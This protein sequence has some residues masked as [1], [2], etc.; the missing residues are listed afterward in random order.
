M[1]DWSRQSSQWVG[2][3]FAGLSDLNN[4]QSDDSQ[5]WGGVLSD[6][7]KNG[8]GNT[9]H[10]VRDMAVEAGRPAYMDPAEWQSK[11]N[12]A[13]GLEK[14]LGMNQSFGKT[15]A[16]W[17]R[18]LE[19]DNAH[20]YSPGTAKRYASSMVA[21]L[22]SMAALAVGAA[23]VAR[24]GNVQ[25]IGQTVENG[26]Y[27]GS[28]LL[29][30]ALS[31]APRIAGT[32]GKV[33]NKV[34]PALG[35]TIIPGLAGGVVSAIPEAAME[36]QNAVDDYVAE[37][38]QNNTY[39][40]GQTEREA[41]G[42]GDKVFNMNMGLLS[43]TNSAETMATFTKGSSVFP[44]NKATNI[45]SR[46]IATMASEGL[47]EGSQQI[48][49]KHAADKPWSVTDDD[50]KESAL[51]GAMMGGIMHGGGRT[52]TWLLDKKSK[53][54]S[55]QEQPETETPA[56]QE[57]SQIPQE[58]IS[59][60]NNAI[61]IPTQK[62]YNVT[63][64][65]SNTGLT[66]LTETKLN[67][68]AR[69]YYNQF[70]KQL[71]ITSMK[72][73]GDGSSWHDS[74][75]AVDIVN[76]T[77]EN[78][79]EARSW[80]VAQGQ[81]YGLAALDEYSNPSANATGGHIHF[82]DHGEALAG[83]N[84]TQAESPR[85]SYPK[86]TDEQ[87]VQRNQELQDALS[88]NDITPE[89]SAMIMKMADD[90][91][92][93]PT[94][95]DSKED[96]GFS[97][98]LSKASDTHDLGSIAQLLPEETASILFPDKYG[99]VVNKN[100]SANMP[101]H[102][103]AGSRNTAIANIA[104]K[105]YIDLPK[106]KVSD[107]QKDPISKGFSAEP[108]ADGVVRMRAPSYFLNEPAVRSLIHSGGSSDGSIQNNQSIQ[109]LSPNQQE[110][111]NGLEKKDLLSN[112]SN[113]LKNTPNQNELS[114]QAATPPEVNNQ[115]HT[116]AGDIA[117]QPLSQNS[118]NLAH[119]MV[120]QNNPLAKTDTKTLGETLLSAAK[121]NGIRV[122]NDLKAGLKQNRP[123]AIDTMKNRLEE[124]GV[125]PA[126]L[127]TKQSQDET[128][129]E[130]QS[131][132]IDKQPDVQPTQPEA[133]AIKD[134]S[135]HSE[136]FGS[137]DDALNDMLSAFGLEKP[138]SEKG[139]T[140][141]VIDDSE[142]AL[143][144]ALKEFSAEMK[145]L[146]ANA[147]FNPKLMTAAFKVGMIHLQRGLNN[148]ADWSNAMTA[149]SDQTKPFLQSTWDAI[150]AYPKDLKFNENQMSAVMRYVGTQY[151]KGITDKAELKKQL[152]K[153]IGSEYAN[154][155]D[156]AYAGVIKYPTK[157]E[158]E[159]VN[160]NS[161]DKMASRN[162]EGQHKNAVGKTVPGRKSDGSGRQ[163]VQST[164]QTGVQ[165]RSSM[166]LH[167]NSTTSSGTAGD[168]RI[169][170][171]E[172]SDSKRSTGSTELSRSVRDSYEG[173]PV[174]DGRRTGKGTTSSKN[175]P[176]HETIKHASIK[177][178]NKNF[179]AGDTKNIRDTLPLLLPEQQDD[180]VFAEK[181]LLNNEKT[182]VLFTNGTG[183]GKTFTGLGIIKRFAM[184]GK[185]N[186]L[187]LSPNDKIN[188]E[189]QKAAKKYFSLKV[190]KLKDT[191]DQGNGII[192]TTYA[193][194]GD[195]NQLVNRDWDLIVADES[196]S[197]MS[198]EK[199]TTTHALDNLRAITYHDRGLS[200]RFKRL[201]EK[202]YA[203]V[204][205]IDQDIKDIGEASKNSSNKT[206]VESKLS[207][208][209]KK[210]KSLWD[211]LHKKQDK[212]M[213]DWVNIPADKKPKVTFLSATP[214][215]Y[216][217]NIDYAEGYLFD[218]GK[219]ESSRYNDPDGRE[220]FMM[221]NFG[222]RMR[223][224][225]LTRPEGNVDSSVMESQFHE[226]LRQSGALS[227]RMLTVDKDYDRG[228][229]LVDGGIGNKVDEGFEWLGDSKNGDYR[230]LYDYMQNSFKHHQRMYLLEAIKAR[231]AIDLIKKYK[232]TGKKVVV[233]HD[234]KK[235]G[236]IHPF[237]RNNVPLDLQA[238]YSEFA[239]KRPDLIHMNLSGLKS[240]IVTLQEAFGDDVLLFNGDVSK[241]DREK[242]VQ[243]F[244][245][246]TSGKDI[247][248]VQSDAGQAGISLHDTTGK[249]QRV[250][251]NLGM[252][253]KPVAAIQI[254]GRIYRVGQKSNAIFR[255][256]N[257]GTN[258]ERMA[259]ASKIAERAST[260]ENLALGNEARNLKDSFVNAFEDTLG[261]DEWKKNL[262]GS[263]GE[264][265]GGK[266][267]DKVR[268][269]DLSEFDRSKTFYYGCG[270]KN[271]KT[272]SSEGSDYFATPEPLG[273]KMVEWAN[274][275]PGEKVLEP[276]A[277]H[278][279]IS[280]WFPT[281]T[282][283]TMIEPSKELAASAQMSGSGKVLS[284]S[285]E[286]YYVGNKFDAI[287]M[288]PPFGSGGKTAIEHLA[289]A[290]KQLRDGGRV[291][292]IIPDGP[293]CNKHFEKWFYGDENAKDKEGQ[294]GAKDASLIKEI[295]LPN[296]VFE[297]AGTNVGTKILV[298]DKIENE[299][300]RKNVS[301]SVVDISNAKNIE[302]FFN[303]IKDMSIQ[304]RAK[305]AKPVTRFSSD[306][307]IPDSDIIEAIQGRSGDTIQFLPTE[308]LTDKENRISSLGKTLNCQVR[309]FQGSPELRGF[310]ASGTTYLNRNGNLS[311][312][313]TFWHETFHWMTR[314]NNP[315]FTDLKEAIQKYSILDKKQI[316]YYRREIA[317]G[318]MIDEQGKYIMSDDD[319]IEEMMADKM[320]DVAG[321]L[322]LSKVLSKNDPSLYERFVQFINNVLQKFKR[323]YLEPIGLNK[324]QG[325]LMEEKFYQMAADM[326]DAEGNRIFR[327]KRGELE[328]ISTGQP[329][330]EQTGF[331]T[332]N[333]AIAYSSKKNNIANQADQENEHSEKDAFSMSKDSTS[334]KNLAARAAKKLAES[335]GLKVKTASNVRVDIQSKGEKLSLFDKTWRSPSEIAKA[336]R[337]FSIFFRLADKAVALQEK[338][339]NSFAKD[340]KKVQF[341][342]K[343]EQDLEQCTAA[344][345][346]GD[347]EQKEYS[348][349][350]LKEMGLSDNAVHAYKIV[351]SKLK[352]A[353]NLINDARQQVKTRNKVMSETD[354]ETLRK[355]SFVEILKTIK[356]EDG[357]YLVSY[358]A[359]KTWSKQGEIVDQE[360][361]DRFKHDEN[362]QVT[363]AIL[364]KNGLYK[365]D[366]FEKIS[367]M[368]NRTGY[369]SHFFHEYMVMEKSKDTTTQSRYSYKVVGSG[370]KLSEA[371]RK[372]ND[373]A[374]IP[375]NKDKEYVIRSKQFNFDGQK[376]IAAVLGD[377]EFSQMTKQVADNTDMTLKE[378]REFLHE[379]GA[380]LKARHRFFGNMLHRKGSAGFE[381]DLFWV[382]NH[383][384]N[385]SSRYVAM[386]EFK[387]NAISQFERFF[388]RFDDDYSNNQTANYV[389]NYIN[390][391][392]GNPTSIEN[393]LNDALKGN[394]FFQSVLG[395]QFGDR[396][397][398]E[399][400]A[401]MSGLMAKAKL[402]FF[403]TSSALMNFMQFV[404]IASKV[405]SYE[406]AMKGLKKAL[407][408]NSL[409]QFI[410]DESGALNDI[411][412][413]ADAGG[414]SQRRSYA[415]SSGRLKGIK[416]A[417]RFTTDRVNWLMDKG[418]FLFSKADAMMRKTAV[419]A[420]YY[421][422]IETKGF[423]ITPGDKVSYKALEY[424][425]EV[426]R[427]AN[428]DYGAH[429]T[430]NMI[431]R[432]SVLTQ[433]MFQ[434]Q[435]YPIK[436]LEFMI[437]LAK[438]GDL[439]QNARFWLPF[440][441]IAGL[442]QFPFLDL[443]GDLIS[444]FTGMK[445]KEAAKKMLMDFGAKGPV[446]K[447]LA[448]TAMYGI[449]SNA[450]I[451]ISN[452]VGMA[453]FFAD[454]KFGGPF[455][456]TIGGMAKQ[457]G[458]G[459]P[460]ETIKAFSPA[461][462][463]MLQ[464][465]VGETR[466]TRNRVG[467]TYDSNYEKL[468]HALGFRTIDEAITNDLKDAMYNQRNEAK[469][470]EQGAIDAFIKN[471]TTENR[472]RLI[473]LKITPK[474]IENERR[475]KSLDNRERATDSMTKKQKEAMKDTLEF[476]E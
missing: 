52:A 160:S 271:S 275:K 405:N 354:L 303:R 209:K 201:N 179:K 214:F 149:S 422:G 155:V 418:M 280:R 41:V 24:S 94:G 301:S 216:V 130:S 140:F 73:D 17:G 374:N 385:S 62:F 269:E 170:T 434:F 460:I 70:G 192:V 181:R 122:N 386:E 103:V 261:T 444:T 365:V 162:G 146:S 138:V 171:E 144:A 243:L 97:E 90:I 16:D 43:G 402:G 379:S 20:S 420:A 37:A 267:K 18:N 206:A 306:I 332:G 425:K 268:R 233:F 428:F 208:L 469:E 80:L 107:F 257:T 242:N 417:A 295:K 358:K 450:G 373:I 300:L 25:S 100:D 191:K 87:I 299:A 156:S 348:V 195:N 340:M 151:D 1:S 91:A 370:K 101:K 259:F 19:E 380:G 36:K 176:D 53:P 304:D 251:M 401:G 427:A 158:I 21:S 99:A 324:A 274:I 368:V 39:V 186:I 392:N 114:N 347:A 375:E 205:K 152:E 157:E 312:Q 476:A 174:S 283:N 423:K 396:P 178:N 406:Y 23:G 344:L 323:L 247:I 131:I 82:S 76:D 194:M 165:S 429:D 32:I 95:L 190:S 123:I 263:E 436:Q 84:S 441:L 310:H 399:I 154:L 297:R 333:A 250:L 409:D 276:S 202:A 159:N 72:R 175:R 398:L 102:N 104:A 148:F 445:P 124:A 11:A 68:L 212:I 129:K 238:K 424:A 462:G 45:L 58:N 355:N 395:D 137:E 166:H 227:G 54:S 440:L 451:D 110:N 249:H 356:Q 65:V 302:E 349:K 335:T 305:N 454:V 48:I 394:P 278:G 74:G 67:L 116:T 272:K 134:T 345:W 222:Y 118:T 71:D 315:L 459:N 325:K 309:F 443:F 378:A 255:Y 461:L 433:N 410:I 387:P 40:P 219:K 105:G 215:A 78:D 244:N 431:R 314:N 12:S 252:P 414:Y 475:K 88:T 5:G 42:V 468:L 226:K 437:D 218:Y 207:L 415:K 231:G 224:N 448:D 320:T 245:D 262:P 31:N 141:N 455:V 359:P 133:P 136:R 337:T 125:D 200:N 311:P 135:S 447:T 13:E 89:H 435:K 119:N 145:N 223:Y 384:F 463:N 92:T 26:L 128:P 265:I 168:S 470:D 421:Q 232:D 10:T 426:D 339:R 2:N 446:E 182:G 63:G 334:V 46:M 113:I 127:Q 147:M 298:I 236:A 240:P 77:L 35:E 389:K 93:M 308:K 367:P 81:K 453:N 331:D 360:T 351:R 260:A 50:V 284:N 307:S 15:V 234:F 282:E 456:S 112:G 38:K 430:P 237:Q 296:V 164:N 413:S 180:V 111:A 364:Q 9:I 14:Y 393:A 281:D 139:K 457:V 86:L 286:D 8:I 229:I 57:Q 34:A 289:K 316:D 59:S 189:W 28:G 346:Q 328:A 290:Y 342:L 203:A 366:Y 258:T 169:R 115:E 317:M 442:G 466:T 361:L 285:F 106:N 403:N 388:G 329:L 412:I 161:A 322:G 69:D 381:K 225:K 241:K 362:M 49:Q 327:Q 79:P 376:E 120:M 47:E 438:K 343:K 390:D 143:N 471:P 56:A 372:A 121:Q 4:Q 30:D 279:A 51:V 400:S 473:E 321:R 350:D 96:I 458:N 60:G 239:S 371:I 83:E 318:E 253:V 474:R 196:Q 22:P 407:H 270:K 6:A 404:N 7:L 44:K 184:Q 3:D 221:E 85:V 326:R 341:Y 288:N 439:K 177:G 198:G 411:N 66:D 172:S 211:R 246:D 210:S 452:R 235:G 228:F 213:K 467:T 357:G 248:L 199:A 432:G 29:Q 277:G 419:L 185:N 416:G 313:W 126:V 336:H 193:N 153:M 197:L 220:N 294:S 391:I 33:T 319:I 293:S 264:G 142:D 352:E 369:L 187:I 266:A 150:N 117:S 287:V 292:A 472:S 382:L 61:D 377:N 464:A 64:E 167:G 183:T 338:L 109:E 397:A 230:D 254:E 449:L 291:V 363:K 330:D 465:V 383:Y 27:R 132:L 273:Y 204:E 408:P 217:P 108:F 75:Q 173:E 163:G 188:T 98:A 256:L 55:P 353:Y